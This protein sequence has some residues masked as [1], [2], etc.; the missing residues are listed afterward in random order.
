M[1]RQL[2]PNST[3]DNLKKEAKRWLKA[4]RANDREARTRLQHA[5][6]KAPAEPSLRDIQHALAQE[7][8]LSNWAELKDELAEFALAKQSHAERVAEFMEQAVLTY[9]IPP[10]TED[11]NPGYADDPSRRLRAAR[12]LRQYPEVARESIHTAVL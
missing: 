1:S 7:H 8:R 4:L 9:G 10:E 12:I 2:T 11:W 5:W 3:L 6:P